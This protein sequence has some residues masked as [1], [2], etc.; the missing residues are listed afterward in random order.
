MYH[1][2]I[3]KNLAV[4]KSSCLCCIQLPL[5]AKTEREHKAKNKN[6]VAHRKTNKQTKTEKFKTEHQIFFKFA[7]FLDSSVLFSKP[8]AFSF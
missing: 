2:V 3:L 8:M 6:N 5:P 1:L 4:I 7:F